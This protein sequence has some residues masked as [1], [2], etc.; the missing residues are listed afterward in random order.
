MYEH[1]GIPVA[2]T[3]LSSGVT[4]I[5]VGNEFACAL[6]TGGAVECWGIYYGDVPVPVSGLSSGVAAIAAGGGH[7]CALMSDGTVDCWQAYGSPEPV[8]G[9][10]GVTAITAGA[11]YGVDSTCAVTSGGAV[12]CWG[13]NQYGQLGDGTTTPSATPVAVS[14]LSSG[15]GAV[16]V[17]G[18]QT[19]ALA[20]AGGV[21]CWGDN[22]YGQLGNG[23]TTNSSTPVPVSGLSSR[24]AIAAGGD[25]SCAVTSGAATCWGDNSSGQLGNGT[26]TDSSTPVVVSG[27]GS[28]VKAIAVGDQGV[29]VGE[30]GPFACA[31]TTGGA[32]VCWGNGYYGDLGDGSINNSGTPVPVV[33]LSGVTAIAAGFD[34]ACALTSGGGVECWGLGYYGELGGGAFNF[35]FGSDTPVPVS[36][37]QGD[38]GALSGVVA[39]AAGNEHACALMSDG[40]V[41]CWGQNSAGQLGDGSTTPRFIPVRV[42]GLS[43][44]TAIAASG[45]NT[46]AVVSGGAVEC[47]GDNSSGQLGSDPTA[48]PYSSTPVGVGL[49]QSITFG[50]TSGVRYGQADFSPASA[51][52]GLPVSYIAAS[53]ACAVDAQGLVQITGA[54]DC[55]VAASQSGNATFTAA[56][57]VTGAFEVA[58]ATLSVNAVDASTTYGQAPSLS[59]SLSGFVNGEDAASAGVTGTGD[60]EVFPSSENVGTYPISCSPGTAGAGGLSAA[61]YTFAPG[62]TAP[63]TIFPA[64]LE[65]AASGGYMT[66]GASPPAISPQ[67]VG[68]ENGDTAPASPPACSTSATVSSPV[69]N[70]DSAC[71]GAVDPN[72]SISYLPGTVTVAP[73]ALT[74]TITGTQTYGGADQAFAHAGSGFFNGEND[75]S[76]VTGTLS[77]CATTVVSSDPAGAYHN[78]ISGCSGLSAANYTIS[79]Q[80]G[81]YTVNP[82]PLVISA[83]DGT[84]VYGGAAPTITPSYAT[85]VNADSEASLTT[86]PTCAPN[87]TATT[88]VPGSLSTCSGAVDP[89][90]SITYVSGTVTVTPAALIET[91]TGAQTYGGAG[92]GFVYAGSGFINGEN[93]VSAVTGALSG[94]A[95][96]VKSGDPAGSYHNT[97]SGCSGLSAANYT[98]SYQYGD[99]TVNQ[100]PLVIT[101]SDGTMTYGGSPPAISPQYLGLANGDKAPA[102]APSCSTSATSN[103]PVGSYESICLGASDSNYSITY[104]PGTVVVGPA[105]LRITASDGSMTYGGTPPTITPSYA[106]FVN[107]DTEASLTTKPTCSPNATATTRVPGSSSTCSGAVDP[108]YS[109]TY[110]SGTVTVT[111]LALIE[112]ITGAQTYGGAGQGFAHAGSGFVNGDSDASAVTGTL[113]GCATTVKSSDPAASYHNAISGC[114]GLSAANYT[115]SYQYGDYTVNLAPLIITAGDGT[116][117]YGGA[118]PTI[119][120]SY[121]TFVNGDSEASL[122]TKPTCAPNVTST[123]DAGTY[124]STCGGA[125]DSNYAISYQP[126]TVKITPASQTIVFGSSAPTN[127]AVGGS[128]YAPQASGGASGNSVAFSIDSSSAGVC[129]LSSGVVSF[130][131]V[132]SC[133]IDANQ[134]ASPPDYTAAQQMQ[135]TVSVGQGSQA[136]AFTSTPSNL[137][138]GGSYTPT[139]SGG[140]SGNPVVF[141]VDSTSGAGVCSISSGK[142]S[143]TAV[144]SCVIDANQAGN[145]NYLPAPQKQQPV[146]V[147]QGS[148]AITFTSAPPSP[149]LVG[150]TYKPT[151]VGGAS[152]NPVT[153]KTDASS[154][155][156]CSFS[157]GKVSFTAV[158]SCVID[159]NQAGNTNYTPAPQVQQTVAV[160]QPPT[161]TGVSPTAGPTAGGTAVT[162]TGTN[163]TAGATVKFGAIASPNVTVTSSTQLT[164]T[165]PAHGA[166]TVDVRVTTATGGTSALS[167]GDKYSYD[168]IPTVT[169]TNPSAVALTGGTVTVTGTNFVEGATTVMFG[170]NAATGVSVVSGTQLTATTPAAQAGS[171]D[172]T[173]TTPGGTSTTSTKDLFAYGAPTITSFTPTTGITGSTVTIT[174]TGFVPGV[175]VSFGTLPSAKV[176]LSSGTALKAV[177]PNGAVAGQISVTSAPGLVGTSTGQ[178]SP[179]LS[180]TG[181]STASGPVG[182]PVTITGLGFNSS[183]VVKFNGLAAP[184]PTNVTSTSLTTTVPTSLSSGQTVTVTVTN[185]KTPTG[186]VQA[187]TSFTVA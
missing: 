118:P 159:A 183:S 70:Y 158:G 34:F 145:T 182:T 48:T 41:E 108:N 76:A 168:A 57:P 123:T 6:T 181:L 107:G 33:G 89:N 68:L 45:Q 64:S 184:T 142:V 166:G 50:S 149:A 46:C 9:L 7:A 28:G 178:F 180:I 77:G 35:G 135:Q 122:T 58:P 66:Y 84:M 133:V 31:L 115:I 171:V 143:F 49:S 176:T 138:V 10:S 172:V 98:I 16:A 38:G 186:T 114:S 24:T 101:A 88:P 27:L 128:T 113:S 51:S 173:V 112:T 71:S 117:V 170:A 99:Y 25:D 56:A 95:T 80:Y 185:T 92:E 136:I 74:E 153:F 79:Y 100:A 78:T 43:G 65:V 102:T 131:A 59:Y 146:T 93:D 19:C 26:I 73:A 63:L 156:V 14:G 165:A 15:V 110:V 132:G 174:G 29:P 90:Y 75:V 150:A 94:C 164:A 20:S 36:D 109:I 1:V 52:S 104:A 44:V 81:D 87:A 2:V 91:I 111:P 61:N 85:F 121:A 144:G 139:A 17:G 141:G 18:G 72:Y 32:V 120:P 55:T 42:S 8:S 103:S 39:I 130:T 96:T 177:V 21:E 53:G 134:A 116:M 148:Q 124:N 125:E 161:V 82:A 154:A 140:A 126:G 37:P 147:G 162:V 137:A 187:A 83:S 62:G 179:T 105:A 167:T 86:K 160:G 67:Y 69:G 47:W 97:I 54:G 129:S 5:A 106:T 23:T 175:T 30:S 127:A 40:T 22:Q 169:G 4:A 157:S 12:E 60:C 3:G 163:F 151:A 11:G 13:D 152:G 155:G 119:T